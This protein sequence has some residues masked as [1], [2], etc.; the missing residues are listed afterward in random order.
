MTEKENL[1]RCRCVDALI[2]DMVVCVIVL[3]RGQILQKYIVCKYSQ[4]LRC[5]SLSRL[6]RRFVLRILFCMVYPLLF[7]CIYSNDFCVSEFSHKKY[8]RFRID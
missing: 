7:R 1:E 6:K 3:I 4:A 8:L 5:C 2:R